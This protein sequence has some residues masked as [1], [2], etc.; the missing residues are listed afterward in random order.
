MSGTE[1]NKVKCLFKGEEDAPGLNK[2]HSVCTYVCIWVLGELS[3][4]SASWQSHLQETTPSC[5]DHSCVY[6]HRWPRDPS[7]GGTTALSGAKK[8]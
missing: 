1:R 8:E 4:A 2:A 3:A 6:L 7:I 5:R